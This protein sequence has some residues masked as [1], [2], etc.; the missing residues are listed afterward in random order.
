[1]KSQQ[2]SFTVRVVRHWNRLPS[3]VVDAQ[4]PPGNYFQGKAGSG[5][6]QPDLTVHVPV[7]CRGAVL[8]GLQRSLPTLRIL[9]FH[10]HLGT[11]CTPNGMLAHLSEIRRQESP[12]FLRKTIRQQ[13]EHEHTI[14]TNST[15][16]ISW[17]HTV[18]GNPRGNN[19]YFI[20]SLVQ[21]SAELRFSLLDSW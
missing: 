9:W 16:R 4:P 5:P 17:H 15:K 12:R 18:S 21:A 8:D 19:S 10:E 3:N 13:C 20:D 11:E 2:K 7:H 6:R 1:M 14:Y